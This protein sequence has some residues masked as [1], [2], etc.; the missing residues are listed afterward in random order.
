VASHLKADGPVM[1][2]WV[3]IAAGSLWMLIRFMGPMA[4][5]KVHHETLG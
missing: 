5:T 3:L 4:E 1:A 2:V